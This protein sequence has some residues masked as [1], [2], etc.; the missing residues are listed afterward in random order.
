MS[1]L[2]KTRCRIRGYVRR[3]AAGLVV[4]GLALLVGDGRAQQQLVQDGRLLDANTSLSWGRYNYARPVSPLL[5]GNPYATGN[6]GRG[7]SLRSFAP[8]GSPTNF[9]AGL[10]SEL[11]ST[12]MRDSVSTGYAYRP[13]GG[14]IPT[15]FFDPARTAPTAGY[16][17]GFSDF[18]PATPSQNPSWP[19]DGSAAAGWPASGPP[20]Y[21]AP[22]T[23]LQ[24]FDTSRGVAA[25]YLGQPLNTQLSSGIFGP[26]RPRLPGPLSEAQ[27][28][29]DSSYGPERPVDPFGVAGAKPLADEGPDPLDLRVWAEPPPFTATPLD[30]LLR[31][32]TARLAAERALASA[33]QP[34][35]L[36]A[37]PGV[38]LGRMGA[39]PGA[40]G[41]PAP[42]PGAFVQPG[43]DVFTDIQLA[44]ELSR[45]A[46]AEWYSEIFAP[47]GAELA[48][49]LSE[50][51]TLSMDRQAR[52]LEAAEQFLTRVFEAPLQTFVGESATAVNEA[53]REAEIAMA[54]GRYY[55]AVR[56]Y[57]QVR[58]LDPANPLPLI[59]KGHALLAAGEYVSAAVSLILGL[60]RFPE[61][62]SLH[63][64]LEALMGGGEIVD[65]RRADLIRQ[66][67]RREDAQLRFLLGYL[68]V[69][70]GLI[71]FGMENLEKAAREAEPGS[72][73]RRYPGMIRHKAWLSPE[74]PSGTGEEQLPAGNQVPASERVATEEES[75]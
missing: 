33:R 42:T 69:H 54:L 73:I 17:R 58:V 45:N 39:M 3:G 44:L 25:Q 75:K 47:P 26:Q 34:A 67:T 50:S 40:V 60:G 13:G 49:P 74:L 31:E 19:R 55:D 8:I 16:L 15:P 6:V 56:H 23:R 41:G 28:R 36:L 46:Q 4:F 59:G 18:R 51:P 63:V 21:G 61:L 24:A 22:P 68:E 66:L 2:N 20:Q 48:A 35:D 11:L 29:P 14:L 32:N 30:A 70:S 9:R 65:V 72:L 37:G 64:D 43:G 62:A 10:G 1:M 7:M 27:L 57:E 71:Q 12:F 5:G 52:A 53:M 38:G